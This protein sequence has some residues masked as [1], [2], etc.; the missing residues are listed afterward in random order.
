MERIVGGSSGSIPSLVLVSTRPLSRVPTSSAH[1][2]DMASATSAS[3]TPI[4]R[5]ENCS[6]VPAADSARSKAATP[7][8]TPVWNEPVSARCSSCAQPVTDAITCPPLSHRSV[9]SP[10]APLTAG[11]QAGLRQHVQVAH[12]RD[13]RYRELRGDLAGD[14]RPLPQQVQD[15]AAGRVGQR[16]PQQ[17]GV[18]LQPAAGQRYHIAVHT[19]NLSIT[20]RRREGQ[21]PPAAPA[22]DPLRQASP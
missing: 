2:R 9:N 5:N 21:D 17:A 12:H 18:F 7:T 22:P 3:M 14:Q 16:P 13:P 8:P 19:C 1:A 20:Y 10:P 6:R 11:H 4:A 15:L